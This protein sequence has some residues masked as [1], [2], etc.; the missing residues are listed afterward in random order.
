[1]KKKLLI[2]LLCSLAWNVAAARKVL[3]SDYVVVQRDTTVFGEDDDESA[4]DTI[5]RTKRNLASGM[6]A[7]DYIM[8]KRYRSNGE[9]FTRKWD[10]H[11]F[12]QVGLGVEQMVPP[13]KGYSFNTLSAVNVGVGKQFNKFNSFR[14]S[15][16]GAWGYQQS[17]DRLFTK[18][19]LQLD[20][21]FSLSS[22]F[23]G[24]RPSRLMDV[25]TI[26][27]LGVHYSKLSYKNILYEEENGCLKL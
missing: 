13:G 15:F 24:F 4:N 20:H 11:L 25:S 3:L 7:M 27:G 9:V 12:L 10:D 22:Y 19:G 14:L 16:K 6:D 5:T 26:F 17:K 8:E 2:L 1:M 23:S 18:F 21:M